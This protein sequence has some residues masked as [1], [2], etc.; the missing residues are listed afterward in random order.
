MVRILGLVAHQ[1]LLRLAVAQALLTLTTQVLLPTP[2]GQM[3]AVAVVELK[4]P[5]L[6]LAAQVLQLLQELE[7][8]MVMPA[9]LAGQA[10]ERCP[11]AAVAVLER[12]VETH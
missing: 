8:D 12:Q 9:V 11:A 1:T 5:L 3:V 6:V 7:L 10:A 4:T 2:L